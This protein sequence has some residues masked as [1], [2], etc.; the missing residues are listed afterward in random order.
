M[1]NCKFCGDPV[2]A[3]SVFHPACWE[4]KAHEVAEIFC[5][6]YC[7]FNRMGLSE[8]ELIELHCSDCALVR[9]LNLGL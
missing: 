2:K 5:D 4:A 7:R 8:V 3:A 6:E 9:L 1:P